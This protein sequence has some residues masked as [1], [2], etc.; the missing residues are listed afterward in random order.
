MRAT[1]REKYLTKKIKFMKS[2]LFILSSFML[3]PV[4]FPLQGHNSRLPVKSSDTLGYNIGCYYMMD[5]KYES[6]PEPSKKTE[7]IQNKLKEIEKKGGIK[8]N[9]FDYNG[10]GPNGA[11]WNPSNDLLLIAT[12]KPGEEYDTTL[13]MLND[14]YSKIPVFHYYPQKSKGDIFYAVVP[15]KQWE[16]KLRSITES[17]FNDLYKKKNLDSLRKNNP[18]S[19]LLGK[20]VRMGFMLKGPKQSLHIWGLFHADFGE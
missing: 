18:R 16:K 2:L 5:D 4:M 20:V 13:V 11:E 14:Q 3:F 19:L 1:G 17:D 15:R 7:W 6:T 9:L 8:E 12:F 10:G